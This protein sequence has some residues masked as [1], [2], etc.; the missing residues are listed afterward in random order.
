MQPQVRSSRVLLTSIFVALLGYIASNSVGALVLNHLYALGCTA[1]TFTMTCNYS[2]DL[3]FNWIIYPVALACLFAVMGASYWFA[4]KSIL[5]PFVMSVGALGGF[6]IWFD[7][8]FQAPVIHEA[9]IIN[10][11]MNVLSFVMMASFTLTFAILRHSHVPLLTI[12]KAV[13]TSYAAKTLFLVVFA[14][15]QPNLMGAFELYIL[16]IVYAFGAFSIHLMTISSLLQS[17]H[18]MPAPAPEHRSA[19]MARGHASKAVDG[20]RGVAILLIVV[21]HYVPTRF[22]SFSLG[23]PL[24]AVLFSV[25]GFFFA[26]VLLKGA[27]GLEGSLSERLRA[28]GK[29]LVARHVRLWPVIAVVVGFYLALGYFD[30][31]ALTQ[32]IQKT[33]PYYLGYLG[34]IPKWTYEENAFPGHFWMVS[35]QEQIIVTF[36][37]VCVLLGLGFLRKSLW[38]LV[39]VGIALRAGSVLLFMPDHPSW[40]L[41]NPLVVLDSIAL[42]MLA[43]FAIDE[44]Y[45]RARLRRIALTGLIATI[46]IW[47]CLPNWNVSYFTLVPLATSLLACLLMVTITDEARGA[48]AYQAFFGFSLFGALGRMSLSAFLLHPLINTVI[49]L[50]YTRY[51]ATEMPWWLLFIVGPVVSFGAAYVLWRTLEVPLRRLRETTISAPSQRRVEAYASPRTFSASPAAATSGAPRG[52]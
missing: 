51:T 13:F 43:R 5:H 28:A 47:A 45:N 25:A 33:W 9:Q 3:Q 2:A 8:F 20:L 11:T 12:F 17:A 6:T 21:Y 26:S 44:K 30:G 23:K 1:D 19:A 52:L 7:C 49:R 18:A 4:H 36:S 42:G 48:R 46:A 15:M 16:Y 38:T 14:G 37:L 10:D 22:F 24:N 34:N 32:Q 41:E 40:A 39:V 27:T 35:A 50:V 31:G 29:F